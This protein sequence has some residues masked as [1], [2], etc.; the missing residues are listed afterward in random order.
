VWIDEKEYGK[1]KFFT[2]KQKIINSVNKEFKNIDKTI[3]Y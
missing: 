1:D 3:K 2:I